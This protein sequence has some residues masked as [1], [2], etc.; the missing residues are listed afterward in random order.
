VT[1]LVLL[2]LLV[3]AV[4]VVVL[5]RRPES[6]VIPAGPGASGS[7]SAGSSD[8]TDGEGSDARGDAAS[9]LLARL[10]RDLG[11]G[12]TRDVSELAAP[13]DPSAAQELRTLRDNVRALGVT[14]LSM[15]YVDEDSGRVDAAEQ[16]R[17]GGQA[18]VGVVQ[19]AWRIGGW[20]AHDSRL[21]ITM[22]FVQTAHGARFV[23]ARGDYG[24]PAPLWMLT[25]VR[26]Q[27][28]GRAL[29]LAAGGSPARYTGLADQ[30]V[31]AVH[32][33]LPRWRG[34]LVVEVPANP[35]QLGRVLGAQP[36]AYADIAAVTTTVD[37][38]LVPDAPTHIFVNR[39]VF[40]PLGPRGSQIV[41]SHEAT[42]VATGAATSRMPTWLLEG[43]ADFVALD[44]MGL[45]V[46]VT[47]SQVL[48]RVRK[49]GPPGQLPGP[50]Q[51]D[52][53][54]KALGASYEAAWLACR[55]LAREYGEKRLIAFY[56]AA[57]RAGSTTGPFHS[58]LG[59]DQEAFTRRW[60]HDLRRLAT[61]G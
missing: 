18:W 52:P 10:T 50:Q 46:S 45:P 29:V 51:F 47:A 30:A 3:A 36:D 40:D 5:V 27:H 33:V 15:R 42:H 28:S 6:A 14:G 44:H 12:S 31:V 60:R 24:K 7:A 57:D 39:P 48:A 58:V 2:T 26:V 53:K 34:R 9:A 13:G 35:V 1:G 37:G 22:T 20:D 19:M 55:L 32:E 11:A 61:A 23:T 8:E 56:R 16:Q 4:V 17:L 59:T 54:N 38:S 41:M 49:H 21:E 25:A 43:F